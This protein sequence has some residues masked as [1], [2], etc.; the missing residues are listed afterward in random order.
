MQQRKLNSRSNVLSARKTKK[1]KK[2]TN[3]KILMRTSLN[4]LMS[5]IYNNKL[6]KKYLRPQRLLRLINLLNKHKN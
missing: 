3:Q 6:M 4:K 2:I 5:K 1:P